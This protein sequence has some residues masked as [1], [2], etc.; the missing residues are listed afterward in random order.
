M[1]SFFKHDVTIQVHE[2]RVAHFFTCSAAKCRSGTG[3]VRRFQ[4]KAD[5]SSTANLRHHA[6]RCWG[7][8]AVNA[9][10]KGEF[11]V[12]RSGDIFSSFARQ[13]QQPVTYSHRAHTTPEFR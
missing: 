6:I 9:A 2:G 3:G 11:G 10:A 8:D 1:Y 13:G 5:K 4:D 12:S 7:E